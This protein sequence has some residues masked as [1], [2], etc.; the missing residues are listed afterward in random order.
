M[1]AGE[2]DRLDAV[3]RLGDHAHVGL[4]VDQRP[5]AVAHQR[6]VIGEEDVDAAVVAHRVGAGASWTA[7]S[8]S[9]NVAVTR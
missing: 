4:A 2:C 5:E 9:G 7:A 6:L 8:S 1:P 3:G